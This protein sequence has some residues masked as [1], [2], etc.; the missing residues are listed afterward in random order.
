MDW[1]FEALYNKAKLYAR[2]A[3]DE[4][5]NSALMGFWMSLSLEILARAALAHVHPAL[6]AD[7][8]EP[9]NTH[10]AFGIIPKGVP[11]SIQ[12]KAVF[13][14]C[15]VFIK[16]FT[17]KMSAHCLI[18]ADRRNSELHSGAAAFENIDNSSWLPATYEVVE[19]LLRHVSRNFKDFLTA[20]H[21]KFVENILKDRRDNLKREVQEK[22]A[23]AKKFYLNAPDDWKTEKAEA[24]AAKLDLYVKS[25][26]LRRKWQCPSC[27]MTAAMAGEAIGRSPARIDPDEVT[28]TREVR[29]LPNSFQCPYCR[30]SLNGFQEMKE[31]GLGAVYTVEEEE[32]PIEFF[33]IVPEE[34]VDVDKIVENYY[35][36]EYDNE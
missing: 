16:D 6:L 25:S 10:Y 35:R 13:A 30:L 20:D 4:P 26:K 1:A 19:V 9:D 2:R 17:D 29:V 23:K 15:S 27:D 32:D 14:R 33:G 12:A 5:M 24:F 28:I 34:H 36:D 31:A 3:H 22:V 7:P 18:M 8:R 11:K 21:A